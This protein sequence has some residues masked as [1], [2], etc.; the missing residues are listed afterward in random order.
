[1][2]QPLPQ[3]DNPDW[4][5]QFES[6]FSS[7]L[8]KELLRELTKVH[9]AKVSEAEDAPDQGTAFGLL[10]TAAGVTLALAHLQFLAIVPKDEGGKDNK[11]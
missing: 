6:L 2:A 4:S 7:P 1:M 5:H 11:T 10:K 3:Q 8:G 9:D